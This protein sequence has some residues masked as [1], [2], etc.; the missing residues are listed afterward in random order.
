MANF[1]LVHGAFAGAWSWTGIANELRRAGHNVVT[2]D[3]P[4]SGD[5][6]TPLEEVTLDAAAARVLEAL[7]S[8]EGPSI[9]VGHSMGGMIVTQAAALEP[10]LVEKLIYL[11]AFRP[12]DG[13][14]LLDLTGLPEG[15]DDGV[16]ANI[17]VEGDP[18][19]AKFDLS[20]AHAVLYNDLPEGESQ[21]AIEQMGDQPVALFATPVSLGYAVLPPQEYVVCTRDGAIPVALQRLMAERNPAVIHE[22]DASHSPFFSMP[23]E[24]LKILSRAAVDDSSTVKVK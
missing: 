13:E 1:V 24:V 5:D 3:L 4:G 2:P 19:V 16:Q 15:A 14:S 12:V 6:K 17:T 21:R 20:Q 9:L 11:T 18:P 7:R 8:Q 10:S 22:L 23:D